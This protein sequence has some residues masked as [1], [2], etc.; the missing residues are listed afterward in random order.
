[1]SKISSD[2]DNGSIDPPFKSIYEDLVEVLQKN[3]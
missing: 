2:L 1:M 3:Y